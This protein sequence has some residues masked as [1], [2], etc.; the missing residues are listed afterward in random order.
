MKEVLILF[1]VALVLGSVFNSVNELQKEGTAVDNPN[2]VVAKVSDQSFSQEV[3]KSD[4]PVLVDFW[5]PWCAPCRAM[6][7]I[8]EGIALAYKGKLKVVKINVDDAA[9]TSEAY[10]VSS[11]PCFCVFR[12]GKV[13][14]RKVGA[15]PESVLRS[16]I[17]KA[18]LDKTALFN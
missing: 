6:S 16:T 4:K 5:A 12:D 17:D 3:L 1:I 15:V 10:E 9:Q 7:P 11:I 13:V 14:G 8:I 18:L 2:S